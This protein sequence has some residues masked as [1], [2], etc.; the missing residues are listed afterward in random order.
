M[1][2]SYLMLVRHLIVNSGP[3]Q[4]QARRPIKKVTAMVFTGK[5]ENQSPVSY[6]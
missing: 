1:V 4:E 2:V 5:V 6:T 3:V